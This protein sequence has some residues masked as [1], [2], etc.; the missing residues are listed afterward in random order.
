[1]A[2]NYRH[3]GV[4]TLNSTA[5]TAEKLFIAGDGS[6]CGAGARAVGVSVSA[7]DAANQ[8]FGVCTAGVAVVSTGGSV[9]AGDEVEADANGKAIVLNTGKANGIVIAVGTGE[10]TIAVR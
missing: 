7:A 9:S 4:E 6:K 2:L 8:P 3:L 10:A 5:E 1:M